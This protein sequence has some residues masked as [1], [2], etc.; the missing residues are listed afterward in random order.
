MEANQPYGTLRSL[1]V[2]MEIR[3]ARRRIRTMDKVENAAGFATPNQCPLDLHLRTILQ[4]ILCSL[5]TREWGIAAEA[6]VMLQDL[7]LRV[8]PKRQA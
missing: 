7:E 1:K 5:Q 8:R 4:A 6:F 3:N 2:R